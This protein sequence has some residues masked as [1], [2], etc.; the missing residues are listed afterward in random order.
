M[1]RFVEPPFNSLLEHSVGI[2]LQLIFRERFF[3]P[4]E[5]AP[6]ASCISERVIGAPFTVSSELQSYSSEDMW[7]SGIVI[8]RVLA[9]L[10]HNDVEG[11]EGGCGNFVRKE[12]FYTYIKLLTNLIPH[13]LQEKRC[14]RQRPPPKIHN[15]WI[16]SSQAWAGKTENLHSCLAAGQEN[17]HTSGCRLTVHSFDQQNY[18]CLLVKNSNIFSIYCRCYLP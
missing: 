7:D 13:L 15:Q 10:P 18:H 1:A 5:E 4:F 12:L 14:Y 16:L 6:I 8:S 17:Y 9:P 3:N 11:T 2:F